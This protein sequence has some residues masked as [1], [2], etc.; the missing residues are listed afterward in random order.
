[1]GVV[2][3]KVALKEDFG[4]AVLG[5]IRGSFKEIHENVIKES[6]AT[7]FGQL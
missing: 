6:R 7:K 5:L 2:H 1:M 3:K 4:G